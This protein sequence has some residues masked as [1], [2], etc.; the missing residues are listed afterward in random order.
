MTNNSDKPESLEKQAIAL[1]QKGQLD[2]AIKFFEKAVDQNSEDGMLRY[3]FAI[4]YIKKNQNKDA[5]EQ[6]KLSLRYEP[7]HPNSYFA[8]ATRYQPDGPDWKSAIFYLAF[9]DL[10]NQS[11][12]ANTS[13]ERLERLGI[14]ALIFD[15]KSWLESAK[16]DFES[17]ILEMGDAGAEYGNQLTNGKLGKNQEIMKGLKQYFSEVWPQKAEEWAYLHFE[18]A[19]K[20]IDDRMYRAAI[21][22]LI[23]GLEILPND[24]AAVIKLAKAYGFAGEYE[25]AYRISQMIDFK[26]IRPEERDEIRTNREDFHEYL[27][28]SLSESSNR[29]NG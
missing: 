25:R 20:L 23:I 21:A 1:A 26:K 3:N 2:E 8:L 22:Q 5:L 6:L 18:N 19:Q 11:P 15:E 10:E 9:L 27:R 12:K 24:H 14:D 28:K 29:K 4:T 16:N 17:I 7:K 13:K